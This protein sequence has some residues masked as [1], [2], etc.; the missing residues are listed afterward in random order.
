M[1]RPS[2]SV[3]SRAY[4]RRMR[5]VTATLAPVEKYVLAGTTMR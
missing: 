1:G 2:R 4:A 5:R 3:H